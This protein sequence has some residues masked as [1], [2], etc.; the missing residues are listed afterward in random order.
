MSITVLSTNPVAGST[1]HPVDDPI[2]IVFSQALD[3]ATITESR[4]I[5]YRAPYT[6]VPCTLTYSQ[7]NKLVQMVPDNFLLANTEYSV[8]LFGGAGG[9]QAF[10]GTGLEGNYLFTFTTVP[11]GLVPSGTYV[12]GAEYF[13]DVTNVF[14]TGTSLLPVDGVFDSEW[15]QVYAI[16]PLGALTVGTHTLY[17]HGKNNLN[18]W[19]DLQSID[20]DITNSGSTST[21][22][23]STYTTYTVGPSTHQLVVSPSPTAG[24]P[25]TLLTGIVT[26]RNLLQT[27]ISGEL[28]S[29]TATDYLSIVG[30]DPVNMESLV[31]IARIDITFN[32]NLSESYNDI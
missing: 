18:V 2:S 8:L 11:G 7:P 15:E 24:A 3:P 4:F 25:T 28:P 32:Y 14:G 31:D 1:D 26:T 6:L 19:G 20:F 5:L 30:T 10:D 27:P 9:I 29:A 12:A 17:V 23:Q 13:V 21:A 16:I 22:I